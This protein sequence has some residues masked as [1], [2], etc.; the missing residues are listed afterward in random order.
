MCDHLKN[1]KILFWFF[2]YTN[3]QSHHRDR[4]LNCMNSSSSWKITLLGDKSPYI[5]I[6]CHFLFGKEAIT[7]YSTKLS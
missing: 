6:E 3:L 4:P 7:P 5:K 1:L 2:I